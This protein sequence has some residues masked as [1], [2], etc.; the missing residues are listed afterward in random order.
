MLIS[1]AAC[2]VL[3][4]L[5]G[6][7]T[8]GRG[9]INAN[10]IFGILIIGSLAF[11]IIGTVKAANEEYFDHKTS[12]KFIKLATQPLGGSGSPTRTRTLND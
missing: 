9:F 12:I 8:L 11:G 3:T 10:L 1:Y 6:V 7:L 2:A 5:A 4:I